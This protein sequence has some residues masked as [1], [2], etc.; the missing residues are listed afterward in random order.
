[1]SMCISIIIILSSAR[2]RGNDSLPLFL[3]LARFPPYY[4]I[5]V[6]IAGIIDFLIS[7]TQPK[8]DCFSRN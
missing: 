1:M 4:N 7:M 5:V 6:I 8:K 2:M 3:I